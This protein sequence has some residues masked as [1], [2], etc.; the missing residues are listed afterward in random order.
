MQMSVLEQARGVYAKLKAKRNG[1]TESPPRRAG[2]EINESNEKSSPGY[3]L[4][5]RQSNLT[6]VEMALDNS[7]LVGLDLETT[8]LNPH[9]DR[10]RLLS[11]AC[12]SIDGGTF[13]YLVDCFAVDPTPLWVALADKDLVLHNAAF[14]ISFLAR[15]GFMPTKAVN[16]TMLLAQL[17]SAGTTESNTLAACCKRYLNKVIDKDA[18]R[19]D[20]S[21]T[22]TEGQLA[23]A[24]NDVA[25]LRPLQRILAAKIQEAGLT[26]VAR[27]EQR[28]LPALVW[29]GGKGVG[30]DVAACQSLALEAEINV[31]RIRKELDSAAPSIPELFDGCSS[32]NWNSPQQVKRAMALVGF[33]LESTADE[34]LATVGHPLADLLRQY[35]AAAKLATSYGRSLLE[36][37][38][39]DGR[40]YSSWRQIGAASGRMSCS[41][42]NLQQFPRGSYRRCIVAPPGRV[43]VKGDYSQI[44][45]RIAAKVSGDKALLDAYQRGE[46]LHTHTARAVLGVETVTTDLRQLA[47]ALNFGLL[48]GMGARGFQQYAK[49]QYGL[50]LSESDAR[51]YR[52]GF[53]KSYPGLA[54]WHSKVR[55]GR[56]T[57]TRTLTGRRR[58]LDQKTPDT[59]RLNTPVQ[60]TGADG[61]KLSLALLWE[62]RDKYPSAF[63]VLAVHDEIVVEADAQ[64]ADAV[65]AW[66]EEAMVEAMA[67]ML[68]P[69]PV[70]VDVKI[71]RTWGG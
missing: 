65:G 37:L 32:W 28:C 24:A 13:T 42:P 16:D 12:D 55:A 15:L 22:L 19:S 5:D 48:Y 1:I 54:A 33:N 66:L 18:Q 23:Y 63:P 43:L 70:E 69:I 61:L 38:S 45:L 59:H 7:S 68:I 40:V 71:A 44:E 52:N 10:I 67:P 53:F 29:M 25:V 62:R 17:L 57:E 56:A 39:P 11:V 4:V 50:N 60:G 3:I 49:S 27:T 20:W 21:G 8:G 26:D 46:D 9:T 47:K 36:N 64:Q 51:R 58:L 14:D 2:H 35:R 31:E 30:F 34:V 6:M 41:D